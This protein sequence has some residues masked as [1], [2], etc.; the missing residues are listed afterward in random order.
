MSSDFDENSSGPQGIVEVG[1]D[2]MAEGYLGS[3]DP[4]DPETLSALERLAETLPER[5]AVL[6]LGCGAGV[7]VTRWL[8]EHGYNVTGV[9]LSARQLE[10]AKQQAPGATFIKADMTEVSFPPGSFDAV[11]SFYAIIHVPR[12]KHA[13]LLA[14]IASWL[15]PGGPFLATWPLTECEGTQENWEGWG[16]TMWW[17]HYSGETYQ[18]LLVEA[19]FGIESAEVHEGRER[20]LWVVA[21]KDEQGRRQQILTRMENLSEKVQLRNQDLSESDA[22]ALADRFAR[23]VIEKMI[24]EGKIKYET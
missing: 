17:S 24:D 14:R 20:W 12:E 1:Y 13:A 15:T 23:E 7:P 8:A 4:S 16:A 22:E 11:V 5:A 21:R 10:L 6:D 18:R 3:K 2:H 9:D 19:G